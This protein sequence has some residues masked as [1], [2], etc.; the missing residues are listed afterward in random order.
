MYSTLKQSGATEIFYSAF[1]MRFS[2]IHGA[3]DVDAH[4]AFLIGKKTNFF[5][6]S[7]DEETSCG[8]EWRA[9]GF[10]DLLLQQR[11]TVPDGSGVKL[12]FTRFVLIMYF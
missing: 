10:A 8:A 12:V 3:D 7:A 9:D 5:F 2:E 6:L 4:V 1:F 11:Y